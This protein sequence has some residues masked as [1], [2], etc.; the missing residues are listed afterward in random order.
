MFSLSLV[1]LSAPS[2][3]LTSS[4]SGAMQNPRPPLGGGRDGSPEAG[5]TEELRVDSCGALDPSLWGYISGGMLFDLQLLGSPDA[6][7]DANVIENRTLGSAKDI[8]INT[9][10]PGIQGFRLIRNGLEV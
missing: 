6:S 1:R 7:G 10:L 5:Q 4:P 2:E 3:S 8:L 9:P